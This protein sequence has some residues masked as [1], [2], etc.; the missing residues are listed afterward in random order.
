LS[1]VWV[2]RITAHRRSS[3]F[4]RVVLS[5]NTLA[6]FI[7]TNWALWF[8]HKMAVDVIEDLI[9]WER[10]AYAKLTSDYIERENDRQKQQAG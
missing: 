3:K 7:M 4:F 8:H 2:Q 9:P 1:K 6:S 10:D 5:H